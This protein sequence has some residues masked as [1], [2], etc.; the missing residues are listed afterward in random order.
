MNSESWLRVALLFILI[1]ASATVGYFRTRSNRSE[2]VGYEA[3]GKAYRWSIVGTAIGLTACVLCFLVAPD[4]IRISQIRIP[5]AGRWGGVLLSL[6]A[7][8][9]MGW[10][11]ATLG[12]N[13]TDTI[14]VRTEAELVESGPYAWVRHPYYLAAGILMFG[15]VLL[16]AN[17]LIGLACLLLLGLLIARTG[18][19]EKLLFERFGDRYRNYAKRTGRFLPRLWR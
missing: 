17:L 7:V 1:S 11:L 3:E 19:E 5:D 10:T 12:R 13:L 18:R 15:V 14:A 9:M 16:T 6:A 8:G 2:R 4:W